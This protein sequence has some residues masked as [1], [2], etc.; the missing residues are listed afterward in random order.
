MSPTD[1]FFLDPYLDDIIIDLYEGAYGFGVTPPPPPPPPP[2]ITLPLI[3]ERILDLAAMSNTTISFTWNTTGAPL[4]NYT[5]RVEIDP[6]PFEENLEDNIFID[7]VVEVLSI[8]DVSIHEISTAK[9]WVYESMSTAFNITVV[10]NG[11]FTENVTVLLY[12]NI[13]EG[14]MI[15]TETILNLLPSE[16]RTVT[17]IWD[18]T[19]LLPCRNHT[20]TS[21]A[22]INSTDYN[23][24][25]NTLTYGKVHIRLLGDINGDNIVDMRDI[26][27]IVIAYGSFPGHARWNP[28]ADMNNDNT[29]DMRDV[30]LTARNFG[31]CT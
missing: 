27:A 7:G 31:R 11:D 24:S 15:G 21:I 30:A 13:T 26:G 8:H 1:T 2:P 17:L 28:E 6:L 3:E 18:T 22:E 20:I 25:D 9:P 5:I 23:P 16:N 29:I 10:N 4:D 14:S 19:G 12:Y